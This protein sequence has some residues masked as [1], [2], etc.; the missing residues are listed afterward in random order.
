MST[1]ALRIFSGLHAGAEMELTDGAW[2]VGS[3]DSCD[4]VLSDAG[5][6]ERHAVV[7]VAE[8]RAEVKPLDGGVERVPGE[9][10]GAAELFRLGPVLLAWAPQA[11]AEAAWQAVSASLQSAASA[12]VEKRTQ[13][14]AEKEGREA[15]ANEG[16]ELANRDAS[17]SQEQAAAGR[18]EEGASLAGA[19]RRTSSSRTGFAVLAVVVLAAALLAGGLSIKSVRTQAQSWLS[20]QGADRAAAALGT[21]FGTEREEAK[22][23]AQL[24]S[25][26]K[27]L[28]ELKLP[29]ISTALGADGA[30]C[31]I[32]GW[33]AD[34]AERG[35]VLAAA[36]RLA[37]PV[38]LKIK[39]ATDYTAGPAAALRREGFWPAVGFKPAESE[40]TPDAIRIEGYMESPQVEK[41]AL[42]KASDA[43]PVDA[44]GR[45]LQADCRILYRSDVEKLFQKHLPKA[46][47]GKVRAVYL[48]G[49]IRLEG[50]WREKDRPQLEEAIAAL[51]QEAG[52]PLRIALAEAESAPTAA[53][54]PKLT[55][56]APA[57]PAAKAPD[58][59]VAA[60]SGGAIKFITLATG[61]KVFAGGKLP[62][63]FALE[64]IGHDKLVLSK[65]NQRINFPLRLSK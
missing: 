21:L 6:L 22:A 58:F 35:A 7:E 54:M 48:P 50:S 65:D 14:D 49:S 2:T 30:C 59:R 55:A 39:V 36:R 57:K 15:V 31:F 24:E 4:I 34:D 64:E 1:I 10:S 13:P 27:T 51:R 20:A 18:A 56:S 16:E 26:Q 44:K 42:A 52:V 62:G 23:H 8:G 33:V 43:W 19:S 37:A 53:P 61:E 12:L 47:R 38:V 11:E 29:G 60:V 32:Q 41:A 28:A 46:L 40:A 3:G 25:L 63:G 9:A 17:A 45:R 5:L